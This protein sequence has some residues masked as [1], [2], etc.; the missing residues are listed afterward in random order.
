[1]ATVFCCSTKVLDPNLIPK[2]LYL[3]FILTVGLLVFLFNRTYHKIHLLIVI[4]FV[5]VLYSVSSLVIS[6]NTSD[7]II[8]LSKDVSFLLLLHLLFNLYFNKICLFFSHL[9]SV[10]IVIG[11]V[12]LLYGV[13]QY[14]QLASNFEV[15]HV[16]TYQVNSFLGH[17]NLFAQFILLTL[18]LCLALRIDT[19]LNKLSRL[20]FIPFSIVAIAMIF[21]L[22][23]R[24]VWLSF[25]VGGLTTIIFLVFFSKSSLDKRSRIKIIILATVAMLAGGAVYYFT[26]NLPS[27]LT[28]IHSVVD[29]KQGGVNDRLE[30]WKNSVTLFTE[31]PWFGSGLS[32]WKVE[33]L[34]LGVGDSLARNSTTFF[35]RAHNDFLQ[36]MVERG[37]LGLFA[38]LSF[39]GCAAWLYLSQIIRS[40]KKEKLLLI[41]LFGGFVSYLC[42]SLFSFPNERVEV[43]LL[44]IFLILPTM[45]NDK[46]RTYNFKLLWKPVTLFISVLTLLVFINRFYSETILKKAM[47]FRDQSNSELSIEL[48]KKAKSHNLVFDPHSTPID[49]YIGIEY[50]N[51]N[52]LDSAYVYFSKSYAHNPYHIHVLNNLAS[53]ESTRS[54]F[55]KSNKLLSSSVR[56]NPYFEKTWLNL[57][58]LYYNEGNLDSNIHCFMKFWEL[59]N[60]ASFYTKHRERFCN[61]FI[62]N[63]VQNE[64]N[65]QLRN[66]LIHIKFN[67]AWQIKIFNKAVF[68][69]RTFKSQVM[70][71]A[72][73]ALNLNEK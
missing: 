12:V 16:L 11:S 32:S 37:L 20:S 49:W 15:N 31:N 30:L 28:H 21:I 45:I 13:Y 66:E 22:Q 7:G 40:S 14:I 46:I 50:I 67:K 56:I 9:W 52:N 47:Q 25:I 60:D 27:L 55:E 54:N 61:A 18:F 8:E 24:A 58:I 51:Q 68:E 19:G 63:L 59:S 36:I 73:Y 33:V 65:E 38:I 10:L 6:G 64:P 17:R 34:N 26:G 48:F 23:V 41:V 62:D 3:S 1:M 72:R 57:S 39:L 35:Q 43:K 70:L 71:D 2:T 69:K 29:F 53:I 42:V 44:S 5:Y 4:Y